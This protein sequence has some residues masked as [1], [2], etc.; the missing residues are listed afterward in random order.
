MT[1]RLAGKKALVFRYR[2]YAK[3]DPV[4]VGALLFMAGILVSWPPI[5][6]GLYPAS[7]LDLVLLGVSTALWT[8][9][10]LLMMGT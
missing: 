1:V 8:T 5:S 2:P 3:R 7:T 4:S 6:G 9:G 10:F